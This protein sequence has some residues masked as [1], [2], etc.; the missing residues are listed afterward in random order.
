MLLK[1]L[2]VISMAVAFS[3]EINRVSLPFFLK[4]GIAI[5]WI[6]IAVIKRHGK[7]KKYDIG[8]IKLLSIPIVFAFG[9]TLVIWA[10][11]TPQYV[12][13]S[14]YSRLVSNLGCMLVIEICAIMICKLFGK[15]AIKLSFYSLVLTIGFNFAVVFNEYGA[16]SMLT[17]LMNVFSISQFGYGSTLSNISYGLEI[18]DATFAMGIFLVY[19]IFYENLNEEKHILHIFVSIMGLYLGFKRNALL[20]IVVTIIALLF[21]RKNT[22]EFV[23]KCQILGFCMFVVGMLYV[24]LIKNIDELPLF[25]KI[26]D[27]ARINLYH[28]LSGQYTISPF[29]LGKG[30]SYVNQ[31]LGLEPDLLNS[32]HTDLVRIYIEMGLYGFGLWIWYCFVCIPRELYTHY[33]KVAGNFFLVSTFYVFSTYFLDNTLVLFDNQFIYYLIPLSLCYEEHLNKSNAKNMQ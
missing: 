5:V 24:G 11:N 15:E 13:I 18:H 27:I 3:M 20:G 25:V 21:V 4:Y 29:Y 26:L 32:S 22:K 23:K 12:N 10:I 31:L 8:L 7:I 19:F 1:V 14:F 28:F 33:S 6:M 30:Y 2:Y 9:Y 17:Y 16:S